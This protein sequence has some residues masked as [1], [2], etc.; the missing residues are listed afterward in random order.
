MPKSNLM[1]NIAMIGCLV[2]IASLLAAP[3]GLAAPP[4]WTKIASNGVTD[5]NNTAM[6]PGVLIN[7]KLTVGAASMFGA[8]ATMYTYDTS[9][10]KLYTPG[11]GSAKNI[12]L[13]PWALYD[14]EVYVGT[15]NT[16]T[17]GELWKYSG[18]GNP[19]LVK[20]NGMGAGVANYQVNPVS[21]FR[22]NL[23]VSTANHAGL[24]MYKYDGKNWT[25]IVGQGAAGTIT[26]PGFGNVNNEGISAT[27]FSEFGGK[28]IFPVTNATDGVQVYSY[29][30]TK[31][32][33]I[34]GGGT[35]SWPSTL[36]SAQAAT[37]LADNKLY[38]GLGNMWGPGVPAE[39][40]S[41]NGKK[42]TKVALSG[43]LQNV[44]NFFFQP[45]VRGADLYVATWNINDGCRIYKKSGS[46]FTAFSKNSFDNAVPPRNWSALLASYNGRL[47]GLT[48]NFFTG[49]EVWTTPIAPSITR[50]VPESGP[51]G[52]VVTIEGHDFGVNQ[53]GSTVTFNGVET[54][55]LSWN[56]L[57]IRALLPYKAT[58][59][60]VQ[61]HTTRGSSNSVAFTVTLSKT[62][63]FAEG[64]T[65]NNATDGS[66]ED[67][68]C[69]QNPGTQDAKVTLTYMLA[70]GTTKEQKTTVGKKSRTTISVNDFLGP[71]KDV[72]T[73]VTADQLV[74]A[75]RPMYFNYRGKWTGGH[76]VIGLPLPRKDFYFAEG[77]TRS[78]DTDG[79]FEEWLTILNPNDKDTN[80]NVDYILGTGKTVTKSYPV[81]KMSRYTVDVNVAVGP[82]QDVSCVVKGDDPIVAERPMYF[83]YH[84]KWTGG[85]DIIGAPG[86]DTTFYFAEGTTR[87]N[88]TDG[89]FSE[90]LCLEND[91]DKDATATITYYSEQAGTQ[92]Q[93]VPVPAKTRVTVDVNLKLGANVDNSC[94][95]TSDLPIL[96]ERP[97]YFNYHSA[98]DGGHDVMGCAAPKKNFYFAEGNT[99]PNFA[100]WIAVMNPGVDDAHVTF[101][102]MLGDGTNKD[103]TATV[104]PQKR[105]TRDLLSDVPAGQDVSI[106][107]ES[108]R[109]VVA[110]RPMY[111]N[112][113]GW[114][115]GGHDTLGYGI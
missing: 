28:L 60:P 68:I 64:T 110:E 33:R 89:T 27:E 101:H 92:N 35:G 10:H 1:R 31:F 114:C 3:V 71:D 26:G 105:Y 58:T 39:L 51:Y 54:Q 66:F 76:D 62:W 115:T 88:P 7:G 42:W 106:W 77:T 74:L 111:F 67:W 109:D 38:L 17:G 100:T 70:D 104:A 94:K 95:I 41:Y 83:N 90:W 49:S 22:G 113:H 82:D 36:T 55:V 45:F 65:R 73:L 97:M 99:Q 107:I 86:P 72:S 47:F 61:V 98:W 63:Y 69:I 79:Q 44:N 78:N 21:V 43:G 18:T 81:K 34:G 50:L 9:F 52:T 23:I 5:P 6:L 75:E 32:T 108:D 4:T 56:D 96:A 16:T 102:Y 12:R 11:F 46:G 37:S 53:G 25:Q 8:P 30:G 112:Y 91:N 2:L 59:G 85:H 93:S 24:S 19:T 15:E 84:N 14:G 40:W 13:M 48:G 20:G 103:I 87:D 80:V 57:S 29:D